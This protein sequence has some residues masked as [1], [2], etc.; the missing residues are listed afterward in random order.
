MIT[1]LIEGMTGLVLLLMQNLLDS[2]IN[3]T[4]LN[5]PRITGK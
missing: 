3:C 1:A 2:E 4:T 5:Q